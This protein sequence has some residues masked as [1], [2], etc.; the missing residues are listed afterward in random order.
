MLLSL[1]HFLFNHRDVRHHEDITHEVYWQYGKTSTGEI[2]P[3]VLI[4]HEIP[5]MTERC[6]Q[7]AEKVVAAG[8]SVYLPL[9]FGEAGEPSKAVTIQFNSVINTARI[10]LSR[11]LYLLKTRESSPVTDWLRALC[12]HIHEKPEHS[13]YPGMGAIGM[14]LTGGFVLS[15]MIDETI[16]APV[17]SQPALP[18]GLTKSHKRSLGI[19]PCELEKA[20]ERS[21]NTDILALRFAE[22]SICPPERFQTLE[23]EFGKKEEGGTVIFHIITADE[24]KRDGIREKP[25]SLLTSGKPHALLTEDFA[26]KNGTPYQ[27]TQKAL[28]KV[29]EFLQVRLMLRSQDV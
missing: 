18:F 12:R 27:S 6:L 14:C 7:L 11:E 19:S 13:K 23:K 10:C 22:D 16:M 26:D 5:G 28:D 9:L 21:R 3:A 1:N 24:R 4:M 2:G 15:L 8:F 17:V 20:K 25:N 29:L